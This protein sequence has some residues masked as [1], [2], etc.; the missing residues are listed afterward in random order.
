MSFL[1]LDD[2]MVGHRKTRRLLR[3]QRQGGGLG[4]FG[5]HVL[6]MLHC[7][8][9][10][11]DGFVEDEFVE[12]T[13]DDSRVTGKQ[14]AQLIDGLIDGGQWTRI[15]GG[16]QIHDYLDHNPSRADV[17]DRR[18]KD[19]ERKASGRRAP[20]ND[21][22]SGVR[23]ESARTDAGLR[24]ESDRT[25]ARAPASQSHTHTQ[26]TSSSAVAAETERPDVHRLCHLLAD[27]MLANDPKAKTAPDSKNWQDACRLLLDRDDREPD[28][29]EQVIRWAQA[30]D[31]WRGNILSM[32]KLRE[33]FPQLV[34]KMPHAAPAPADD[35][36]R[37]ERF[38]ARNRQGI[39]YAG[40]PPEVRERLGL[41][42]P[43]AAA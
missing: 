13:L 37:M 41:D 20:S 26:G 19:A 4:S 23:A 24:A 3:G 17:E 7:A 10:L 12:E 30:D 9:Y 29:V 32:G 14:R 40:A 42:T 6:G 34:L 1:R 21:R 38:R 28:L 27:L 36:A 8:T 18:A 15:D 11:T 39:D 25:L 35:T 16:Y 33:Q 31:F 2:M 22:P 5:L 43:G